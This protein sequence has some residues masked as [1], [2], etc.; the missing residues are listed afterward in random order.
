MP[1]TEPRRSL[2]ES[3]LLE[4]KAF[5]RWVRP[6]LRPEDD[7]KFVALDIDTGEYEIDAD[8][9]TAVMRLRSRKPGAEIWLERAGQPAAYKFR[10][11]R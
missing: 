10:H 7:G 5:D 11:R 9:Y 8:D 6:L 2:E 3:G 1:T 4:A